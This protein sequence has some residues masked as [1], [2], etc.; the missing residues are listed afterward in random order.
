MGLTSDI[1]GISVGSHLHFNTS[2]KDIAAQSP[3]VGL[4]YAVNPVQLTDLKQV[5][6]CYTKGTYLS[7]RCSTDSLCRWNASTDAN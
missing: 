4:V 7:E 5:H 3:E 2:H 1:S 6:Q